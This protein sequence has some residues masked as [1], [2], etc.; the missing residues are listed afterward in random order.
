MSICESEEN[1]K[2]LAWLVPGYILL[3]WFFCVLFQPL[4]SGERPEVSSTATNSVVSAAVGDHRHTITRTANYGVVN[5]VSSGGSAAE[6]CELNGTVVTLEHGPKSALIVRLDLS[7][8]S[9]AAD[10]ESS[11]SSSSPLAAAAPRPFNCSLQVK[12]GRGLD[13]LSAVV[14]EMDLREHEDDVR[15]PG[16]H[17]VSIAKNTV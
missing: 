10:S 6:V 13:G 16:G 9:G 7:L 11:S 1:R 5:L 8:L 2:K 14:E 3:A 4:G 12:A 17:W 15:Q